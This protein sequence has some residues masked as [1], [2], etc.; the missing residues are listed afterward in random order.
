VSVPGVIYTI[1]PACPV[2]PVTYVRVYDWTPD[3]VWFGFTS[4]YVGWYVGWSGLVFGFA[5]YDDDWWH[6]HHRHHGHYYRHYD[7]GY[8]CGSYPH[9]GWR[10][11]HHREWR[12]W[13]VHAAGKDRM[14]AAYQD[15]PGPEYHEFAGSGARGKERPEGVRPTSYRQDRYDQ[16]PT[17][18]L[19]G[20]ARADGGPTMASVERAGKTGRM[21][22]PGDADGFRDTGRRDSG[23]REPDGAEPGERVTGKP[24][25]VDGGA[26]RDQARNAGKTVA[27]RDADSDT[28]RGS[29]PTPAEVAPA[30]TARPERTHSPKPVT[31]T[32]SRDTDTGGDRGGDRGG[33]VPVSSGT[34]GERP[35]DTA[36]T[37]KTV[38]PA[39]ERTQP[40]AR[41]EPPAPQAPAK[42]P[43]PKD[44]DGSGRGGKVNSSYFEER[45]GKGLVQTEAPRPAPV[46]VPEASPL[47]RSSAGK[48]SARSASGSASARRSGSEVV[49]EASPEVHVAPARTASRTV[50]AD[51]YEAPRGRGTA[52]AVVDAAT[53]G[54]GS[55]VGKASRSVPAAVEATG[56]AGKSLSETIAETVRGAASTGSRGGGKGGGKGR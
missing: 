24:A 25:V 7:H 2:Y 27:P 49:N 35:D 44:R 3:V 11:D 23:R 51:A 13:P 53:A 4:G 16:E 17:A 54:V 56:S 9:H 18:S 19:A 37:P 34:R 46:V 15:R 30:D 40:E 45:Y 28:G 20:K 8:H 43:A 31:P 14:L 33:K 12:G 41:P 22:R 55:A 1:P 6:H 38:Q 10:Y 5:Y 21:A 26:G 39:P 47:V 52:A 50:T 32:V 42:Q 29:R 48:E 36:P